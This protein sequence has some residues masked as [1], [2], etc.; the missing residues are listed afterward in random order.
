[1]QNRKRGLQWLLFVQ[2][3]SLSNNYGS[4]SVQGGAPTCVLHTVAAYRISRSCSPISE[5]IWDTVLHHLLPF[6]L[7][8]P[9]SSTSNGPVQKSCPLTD[10]Q[11]TTRVFLCTHCS[12]PLNPKPYIAVSVFFFLVPD[13]TAIYYSSFHFLF[14]YPKTW[15]Q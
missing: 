14:H 10:Q 6:P 15:T 4:M 2:G 3:R 9:S 7:I 11:V 13:L 5:Q 1:M 8:W 12:K